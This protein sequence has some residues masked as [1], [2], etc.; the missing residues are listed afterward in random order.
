MIKGVKQNGFIF[1]EK[2]AHNNIWLNERALS[3]I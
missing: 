2:T 1:V 3:K